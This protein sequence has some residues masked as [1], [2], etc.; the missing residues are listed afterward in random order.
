M[1]K[2]RI[3]KKGVEESGTDST[4]TQTTEAVSD[5]FLAGQ[6]LLTTMAD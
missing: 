1:K 2:L 5:V 4:R 6:R 3:V